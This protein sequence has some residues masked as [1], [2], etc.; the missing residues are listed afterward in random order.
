MPNFEI[1]NRVQVTDQ[2][3][4]WIAQFRRATG[5]IAPPPD[6]FRDLMDGQHWVE[7][8]TP[9]PSRRD[10]VSLGCAFWAKELIRV[11]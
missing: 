1:G 2:L 10:C 9:V 6:G 4:D 11:D 7:F 5:M 3:P 8:D